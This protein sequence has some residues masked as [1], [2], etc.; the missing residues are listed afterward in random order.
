MSGRLVVVQG[1]ELG[2]GAAAHVVAVVAAPLVV[3]HEPGVDLGLELTDAGEAASVE[4]GAPAFLEGGAL[5]P[6]AHGVVVGRPGWDPLVVEALGDEGGAE[7]A[8]G[9]FGAVVAEHGPDLDAEAL[10]AADHLLEE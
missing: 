5:E 2:G 6:F 4:R 10:V 1:Q 9:V 3:V 8:G 7:R